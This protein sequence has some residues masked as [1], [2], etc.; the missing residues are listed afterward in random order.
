MMEKDQEGHFFRSPYPR[1]DLV[2]LIPPKARRI[3]DVGCNIG[4]TGRLLREKG[5]EEIFGIEIS[6]LAAQQAKPYYKEII[7]ADVEREMLPFDDQFFDCILYG[8][9]LE[10]LVDP[11]KVLSTHKRILADDGAIICSIPNIRFYRVLKS[12]IFKGRW[13]YTPLGILD[14][15]HLRFFTIKTIE[16]M[17]VETG[18]Q[19]K[20]LIIHRSGSRLVKLINRLAFDGFVDFLVVQYR[21]VGVKS[22]RTL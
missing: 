4:E 6:P 5:F 15:T 8:D 18:F 17:F 3:L 12:L 1:V 11:W 9:V 22:G 21:I 16:D 20:K 7:V 2:E 19:F 13:D 14:R 10:H